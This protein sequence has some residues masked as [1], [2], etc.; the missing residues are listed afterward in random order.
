MSNLGFAFPFPQLLRGEHWVR[1][2]DAAI[3]DVDGSVDSCC[4]E[5]GGEF[6]VSEESPRHGEEGAVESL[7]NSVVLRRALCCVGVADALLTEIGLEG[8]I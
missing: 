6:G 5:G 1:S 2:V 8:S 7:C 4:P 3:A